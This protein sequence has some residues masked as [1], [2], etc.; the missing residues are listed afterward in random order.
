MGG[1]GGDSGLQVEERTP[2][3]YDSCLVF[4]SVPPRTGLSV[5]GWGEEEGKEGGL[6]YAPA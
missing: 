6:I 3:I 2:Q 5:E 1:I 4:I